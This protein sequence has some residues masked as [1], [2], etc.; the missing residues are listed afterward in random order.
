MPLRM[1]VQEASP[2]RFDPG[3]LAFHVV[4]HPLLRGS[5]SV[6]RVSPEHVWEPPG[7]ADP[8]CPGVRPSPGGRLA[9]RR[10]RVLVVLVRLEDGRLLGASLPRPPEVGGAASG[11]ARARPARG[12]GAPGRDAVVR[13][14]GGGDARGAGARDAPGR[15]RLVPVGMRGVVNVLVPLLCRRGQAVPEWYEVIRRHLKGG[16]GY[17]CSP[18]KHYRCCP[19]SLDHQFFA[20]AQ[21]CSLFHR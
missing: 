6:G 17:L 2:E 11:A 1:A 18:Y 5:V 10:R 13:G 14:G 4:G 16:C 20:D 3:V 12:V 9:A 8:V 7:P 15:G 21:T 19:D